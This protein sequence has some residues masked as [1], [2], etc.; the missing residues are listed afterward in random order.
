MGLGTGA[1]PGYLA[2]HL[3]RAPETGTLPTQEP[4]IAPSQLVAVEID[5]V[6]AR[7]A[8]EH[9]GCRFY[10]EQAE[11]DSGVAPAGAA[12]EGEAGAFCVTLRDAATYVRTLRGAS[13]AAVFLDAL[14]PTLTLTLALTLTLTLT[15]SS[16]MPSTARGRRR[17]TCWR[18]SSCAIA[19]RR[20]H[21]AA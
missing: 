13:V 5:P 11:L 17:P 2:H 19:A 18:P 1:L 15:R 12:R 21:R 8:A 14:T 7:A 4:L 6:V 9:L 10:V 3:V 20:W 16:S